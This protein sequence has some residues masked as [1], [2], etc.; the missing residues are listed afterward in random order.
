MLKEEQQIG[1]SCCGRIYRTDIVR[2]L[3]GDCWHP[4]GLT[5]TA[6][7]A[8][9]TDLCSSGVVLDVACGNGTTAS[10]LAK[11]FGCKIVGLDIIL[12]NA[13]EAAKKYE[14][15][16]FIV[17]DSLRVPLADGSFDAAI[18][19]CTL[20]SFRNKKE[21]LQEV[22]RV[23][24]SNGRVGIS[25]VVVSGD[26]PEELKDSHLQEL[27]VAGALSLEQYSELLEKAGFD[28]I[29]RQDRRHEALEFIES[30][31]KKLFIAQLLVGVG[32]L[33][34][35]K[36]T[37]DNAK[38]LAALSKEAIENGKLGYGVIVGQKER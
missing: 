28:T 25:D 6:E 13:K 24:K 38:R 31:R 23:L 26:I 33:S 37:I 7:L 17:S 29:V 18:L 14:W 35:R 20:S 2:A 32:K 8:R 34:V 10:F 27:C 19:E 15:N 16:E 3:L 12:E 5:L 30:I 1:E 9:L 4:G 36:E 11:E 22:S 21:V